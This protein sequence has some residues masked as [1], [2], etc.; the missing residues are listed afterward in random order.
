MAKRFIDSEIWADPWFMDLKPIHKL[1][2]IYSFSNCDK[3]GLYKANLRKMEFDI[4]AKINLQQIQDVFKGKILFNDSTWLIK[5]FIKI[6]YPKILSKP[7]APLHKSVLNTIDKNCLYLD[8]NSL[9]IYY[10]QANDRVQVE[11]E[12]KEKNI[13]NNNI[14]NKN[15]LTWR[16]RVSTFENYLDWESEEYCKLLNNHQWIKT[17]KEYHPNLNVE[18]SLEKA[19]VDFWATKA[20]WKKIK[21]RRSSEIDWKATYQ[22]ALTMKCNQ[23]FKKSGPEIWNPEEPLS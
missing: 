1:V 17:R 13:I 19:H 12:V 16:D 11:E 2:Y 4:G 10:A 21:A 8:A 6:Q 3:S 18:K 15:T 5:N 9:L 20:G 23:V 7:D 22:N 14:N